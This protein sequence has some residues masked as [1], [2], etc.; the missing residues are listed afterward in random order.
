MPHALRNIWVRR[1]LLVGLIALAAEQVWRHTHDYF[2]PEKFAAVEPGRVYRGAWQQDGPMRQIV[3]DYQIKTI[4]ALAHPPENPMA[5]RER[6]L[7]RALGCRWVHVPI[8]DDRSITDSSALF[9]R[10]E[11]AAAA[12]A[13]PANQPVFFH[14]HHGV[15]RASMV[16]IAYRTLY[17]GWTLEQ[18]TDEV[19]RTFGLKRVDKGPDY[20]H[21]AA[22]YRERV[23]PR[24]LRGEWVVHRGR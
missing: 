6:D 4:I 5:R 22:F 17:C 19:A 21:M 15:N 3:K 13:D 14:C 1:L 18:A 23:L 11:E 9:D 10:I 2:F 8:V 7:A 16:Q 12:V 24:R 20:R